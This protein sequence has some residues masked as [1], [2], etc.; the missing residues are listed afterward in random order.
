MAVQNLLILSFFRDAGIEESVEDRLEEI[1]KLKFGQNIEAEVW[2]SF[3]I[4]GFCSSFEHKDKVWSRF[5]CWC[6]F[7]P[8]KLKLGWNSEA[9]F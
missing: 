4:K 1:L 6:L 9:E 7:E 5:C 8:L 2:S 3:L